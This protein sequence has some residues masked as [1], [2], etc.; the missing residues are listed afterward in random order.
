MK[1]AEEDYINNT[2]T[3]RIKNKKVSHFGVISSHRN[4]MSE[5]P[6]KQNKDLICDAPKKAE[7]LLNQYPSLP[8][9][10]T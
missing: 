6:P 10:Q 7:I 4:I 2:I 9:K 3:D 5:Y 1:R 8:P